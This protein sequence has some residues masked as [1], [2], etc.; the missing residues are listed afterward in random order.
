MDTC[1]EFRRDLNSLPGSDA[2]LPNAPNSSIYI[3]KC[4]YLVINRIM[5]LS[6]TS[7]SGRQVMRQRSP[8]V[9]DLFRTYD[10]ITVLLNAGAEF[11]ASNLSLF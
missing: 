9:A 8:A 11:N 1:A 3:R 7:A 4:I 6:P 10:T 2:A 5:S